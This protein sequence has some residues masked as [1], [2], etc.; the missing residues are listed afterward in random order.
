MTI[1]VRSLT[2]DCADPYR[3][4]LWWCEVL[5]VPPCPEDHPGDPAAICI[6]GP[7]QP[8]LL[9]ERVPEPRSVKNRVHLDLLEKR[10]G[11]EEVDRLL[12]LGASFVADHLQPDGSGWVVL[13]DPE[14]NEFCV[15]RGGAEE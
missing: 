7:G 5:G 8:R 12:G 6:L 4:A 14:G 1:H 3:L 15:E 2:I 11:D 10:R 13:A 9:F